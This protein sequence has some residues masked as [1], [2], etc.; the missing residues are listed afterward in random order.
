M[1]PYLIYYGL[2]FTIILP[3]LRGEVFLQNEV[4]DDCY[5]EFFRNCSFDFPYMQGFKSVKN[6]LCIGMGFWMVTV[7][8]YKQA[9]YSATL[10]LYTGF[11]PFILRRIQFF[12][13]LLNP[14]LIQGVFSKQFSAKVRELGVGGFV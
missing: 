12:C 8:C 4:A 11:Q 10:Q 9:F 2:A 5:I 13:G 3:S 7:L 1:N 6:R 14:I